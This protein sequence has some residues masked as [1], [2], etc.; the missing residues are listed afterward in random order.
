MVCGIELIL[1]FNFKIEVIK[2]MKKLTAVLL[3]ICALM[4]NL[5]FAACK[6]DNIDEDSDRR[7]RD[8]TAEE[9]NATEPGGQAAAVPVQLMTREAE[10]DW[11]RFY[12]SETYEIT[13]NGTY[14]MNLS[15]TGE[16]LTIIPNIA[17]STV[18]TTVEDRALDSAMKAPEEYLSATVDIISVKINGAEIT[19]TQNTDVPLVQPLDSDS[20]LKGYINLQIWNGWDEPQQRLLPS[21]T[22]SFYDRAS[23]ERF[24]Q[25]S[26]P[27]TFIE[28]EFIVK[29]VSSA[30]APITQPPST[31]PPSTPPPA[32]N[33]PVN[34][35]PSG[36]FNT[37]LTAEQ[38][39][40]NIGI[41]WNLGNTLDAYHSDNPSVPFPEH[42]VDMNN[43]V[44]VETA[45]I[46]GTSNATTLEIIRRVK[47]AGF[48]TIRIPVTWY[49]MAG[50]APDFIIREDWMNHVQYIV[51]M[52]IS[53]GM[54]VIINTHHDEFI[55]RFD[56]AS[57]GEQAVT[58]LW[59]QI[60][61]RFK[62]YDEKLIFEGLNEP[63][64][65]T[66]DWSQSSD[67]G[68]YNWSG[69]T[70][71]YNTVNRWNQA[72]VNAVRATGGN[73]Q[74]RHLMLAT[75]AAQGTDNALN[76]FSL[77]TDPVSGNGISRFILSVH[78]YSPHNWA[79]NGNGTYGGE[80]VVQN[81]LNRV[82]NRAAAL[83]VPVIMGEFGTLLKNDHNQRVQHAHDFVRIATEFESRS[84][85]PVVMRAIWW[86]NAGDFRI[87][88]RTG[89][90]DTP[91]TEIIQAMIRARQGLSLN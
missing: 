77:P 71:D 64:R 88:N 20:R 26:A 89:T 35:T 66:R 73:N 43:V 67:A 16:P 32:D 45:W 14:K 18:N 82:A 23:H 28:V 13:G 79:H 30:S 49:K 62:D 21:G 36:S 85:N 51:N 29:G 3:I 19:L 40:K 78:V 46:G 41:G 74:H 90:N 59:T 6:S 31:N 72:F 34:Y 24:L 47:N 37:S 84:S 87:V 81:D 9:D 80:S 8:T 55:M 69:N 53:E 50:S 4:L 27:V 1:L 76:G 11:T 65:R 48:D 38:L 33:Q 39:V 42:W 44:S 25:F 61:T 12:N 63:R 5:T 68:A 56:N 70:E 7:S 15:V 86:D 58:A 10:R 22:L 17:V 54:Y 2:V 75:Y 57:G 60:A 91:S 83:G 52:A